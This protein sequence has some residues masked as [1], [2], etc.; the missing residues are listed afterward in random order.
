MI[1]RVLLLLF[2]VPYMANRSDA[3]ICYSCGYL[4]LF[5]GTKIPLTEDF[6]KIPFCNDFATSDSNTV[7]AA[8]VRKIYFLYPSCL[9]K[10]MGI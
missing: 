4:E 3:L 1:G 5:N 6:G 7:T 8:I 10:N 2:I 9:L